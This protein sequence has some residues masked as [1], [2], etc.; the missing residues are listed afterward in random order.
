MQDITAGKPMVQEVAVP[1]AGSGQILVR[2]KAS[3]VSAGTEKTLVEFAGKSLAGKAIARPDM[4]K[5]VLNR[6]RR[7][8]ILPT[9][10]AVTQRLKSPVPLGYSVAGT[11]EKAS[12]DFPEFL[13]GQSVAC[14][15]AGYANHAEFVAVPG[16]LVTPISRDVSLEEGACVA[17]G[18]IAMH[19]L[20]LG[21]GR[22]GESCCVIGL[23]MIGQLVIQIARASGMSVMGIDLSPVRL[24]KARALGFKAEL[25]Q[26]A[27]PASKAV[28]H[29]RGFDLVV[30]AADAPNAG[31]VE[32]A[33]RLARDRGRIV[34]IGATK[35]DLPRNI[36][37][38][39]ELSFIVSR[40]YGPGRYDPSYEERGTDYPIA[41]VRWTEGRNMESFLDLVARKQVEVAPLITH[42]FPIDHGEDAYRLITGRT[43]ESH[44]GVVLTYP[45]SGPEKARIEVNKSAPPSAGSV[46][47]GVLGAGAFTRGVLLPAFKRLP[48]S[49][50]GVAGGRGHS[51]R[52]AADIFGF[53][54]CSSSEEELL[55]DQD[56][57]ALI[58]ATPHNCHA[59]QAVAALKAGKHV[60][61]EKPPCLTPPELDALREAAGNAKGLY[62]VGYN[63]RF[64]P[65]SLIMKN[66]FARVTEPLVIHYRVI[67]GKLPPAHWVA[68]PEQ[69]GG[70]LLGEGCHFVDWVIWFAARR[71]RAVLASA[72]D[73][74]Q[75]F[76]LRMAFD[77][78]STATVDY[79]ASGDPAAG[80]ERI[81]V[82]GGGISAVLDDFRLV[83]IHSGGRRTSKRAWLRADKGH[84]AEAAAFIG[85]IRSGENAPIPLGEITT[86]MKVLF[87]AQESMITGREIAV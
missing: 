41:Y 81:E 72:I 85:A 76:S 51:A 21:N 5:Q 36:Y 79:A 22:V 26:D 77:D 18:A 45:D 7:D 63:R 37:Y 87:A 8:G 3:F 54:Y 80:K 9:I 74:G 44:L 67:A 60:F 23:G 78:G 61:V 10:E 16:N 47:I 50:V 39:K 62:M 32:M 4:V 35:L 25:G 52:T 73:Q 53:R 84:R 82:H 42:R 65:F 66:S 19:A 28:T 57:R 33:A 70:R 15:G 24:E 12:P 48:V 1:V 43:G 71:P 6:I 11:V 38:Q 69:G 20:R 59:A 27:E 34:A 49:M 75:S 30:I 13:T 29:G 46:G 64:A 58:I 86:G 14:C 55:K 40:S 68:D 56:I 17:L 2:V 83:E 31:P